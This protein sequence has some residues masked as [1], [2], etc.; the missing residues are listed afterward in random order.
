MEKYFSR[1]M[2]LDTSVNVTG[3]GEKARFQVAP[4]DF[5]AGSNSNKMIKMS[6]NSFSCFRNWY[7]INETNGVFYVIKGG[8]YIECIIPKG[9][10]TDFAGG[11]TNLEDGIQVAIDTAVGTGAVVSFI[12]SGRKFSIDMTAVSGWTNGTDSF[13]G[14]IH[15]TG[16]PPSSAVTDLGWFNQSFQVLGGRPDRDGA[17]SPVDLLD[18]DA[19]TS[20]YVS[21]FVAQLGTL[22]EIVLRCDL[23]STNYQSAGFERGQP[24]NNVLIPTNILARI[25]INRRTFD[26]STGLISFEDYNDNFS[27]WIT[28][29]QVNS[30]TLY[31]TDNTGGFIQEVAPQQAKYG[32][33]SFRCSLK[34]EYY[35]N[36]IPRIPRP[37][38]PE[39]LH[40]RP[41]SSQI[42]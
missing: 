3:N 42:E 33:L 19:I 14:F 26:S 23:P 18:Y 7:N 17:V 11:V 10:Y 40:T 2:F 12:P 1:L 37:T 30:L 15:K 6:L 25:P 34:F 35:S 21:P 31:L 24:D 5:S 38:M 4:D 27:L 9:D 8:V 36:P 41:M 22:D 16:T 28:N 29:Q 39:Y 13:V 32:N 20:K